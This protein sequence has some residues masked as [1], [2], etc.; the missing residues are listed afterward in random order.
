[1]VGVSPR[2]RCR[3]VSRHTP[4]R[5]GAALTVLAVLSTAC[6]QGVGDE[7]LE[8]L[9]TTSPGCGGEPI[10]T[11]EAGQV[12]ATILSSGGQRDYLVIVPPGYS[13]DV[14]VPV[15]FMFHGAGSNKE[16]QLAY[17][18]FGPIVA[19]GGALLVLPDALGEPPR[20][21]PFGAEAYGLVGVDDIV[22]FDHLLRRIGHDFCIDPSRVLAA[23]LSSG[24]FMA[25]AV[26]CQRSGKVGAVAGVA[27]TMW[28][29]PLCDQAAPVSYTYFHGT[30]DTVVPFDGSVGT[31]A[32]SAGPIEATA[33]AWAAQ[34]GCS[35]DPTDERVGT[36]VVR[37]TW[38]GCSA[39]T[40]LY[41]VEGGGH[42]W[43]GADVESTVGLTT[44]DVDAS[45]LI[46][47][48]FEA[49]WP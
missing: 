45:Q 20:W 17:S 41:I 25:A 39:A 40:T 36:Q 24:G 47:D 3:A 15:A 35:P 4:V 34:N 19:A 5:W 42:T 7:A 38:S 21:S 14:A 8:Q 10:A 12:E 13:P 43:P 37:R 1:M 6:V 22:F 29:A 23:G 11:D 49:T 9:L 2:T 30:A 32:L 16:E 33:A 18:A 26:G 44:Q 46:W 27:A 48:A 31:G 28:V